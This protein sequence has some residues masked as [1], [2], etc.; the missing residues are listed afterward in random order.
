M[1]KSLLLASAALMVSGVAFAYPGQR[2]V[3]FSK[4]PIP[5]VS[6]APRSQV[7]AYAEGETP[8]LEFSKAGECQAMYALNN[9]PSSFYVYMAVEM[10]VE[11]Q[12]PYIGNSISA[13]NVTAG[14][15][16]NSATFPVSRAIAYVSETLNAVPE[17]KTTGNLDQTPYSV[18][19]IELETP[20]LITGEKPIYFGYILPVSKSCYYIPADCVPTEAGVNNM[21]F[22]VCNKVTDTPNFENLSNQEPGSLC[23]SINITGDKLPQN[24]VTPTSLGLST[25]KELGNFSYDLTVK[26]GGANDIS[27]LDVC[28]RVSNGTEYKFTKNFDTPIQANEIVTFAVENVPN[29]VP[30]FYTLSSTVTGI[31]GSEINNPTTLEGSFSTFSGGYKRNLVIEEATG[32]WCGYCP[33]GI[34]MMEYLKEK[35]PDWIRIAIHDGDAM[36]ASGYNGFISD[37]VPGYPYSI[38]NRAVEISPMGDYDEYYAPAYEYYTSFPAYVDVKMSTTCSEDKK[39]VNIKA[40]TEFAL[41]LDTQHYLSFVIVEDNVGPYSQNNGYSGAS[42]DVWGWEKKGKSVKMMYDDVARTIVDY[43]GIYGSLP[44]KI[45]ADKIYEYELSIP[46]T[47]V[48]ND[49]FRVVAMVTNNKTKEIVNAKEIICYKDNG[50]GVEGVTDNAGS[51]DIRVVD[52]DIIV[53]GAAN[54]AVYTLDGR[55]VGTQGLGNG[56]YIVKADG[57]SKK[58]LV[59]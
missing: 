43:P 9:T 58:V 39:T 23:L 10:T 49:T 29:E 27:S 35:Y 5:S 41:P 38:C 15:S 47:S 16:A 17:N 44:S 11:D 20:Y 21:L 31:N 7:R 36:Q 55:K 53:T 45:E 13:V 19:S 59:K 4:S 26:N 8:Y 48:K 42:Y 6:T 46:I 2:T 14:E 22:A 33:R 40:E 56:V 52:G 57:I 25:Y 50:V 54:V 18:T 3:T 51:V 32:T 28:T 34:V 24:I 37:F 1:K 30:G 12:K